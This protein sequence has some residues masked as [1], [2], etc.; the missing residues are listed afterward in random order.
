MGTRIIAAVKALIG[1]AILLYPASALA[2]T[3]LPWSLSQFPDGGPAL[4]EAVA[5]SLGSDAGLAA[6][7]CRA[8]S[9]GTP[10][11]AASVIAGIALAAYAAPP[12][13]SAAIVEQYADC[14]AEI[15]GNIA[16]RNISLGAAVALEA[17]AWGENEIGLGREIEQFVAQCENEPFIRSYDI[18]RG[19]DGLGSQI[20][21]SVTDGP[22]STGSIPIDTSGGGGLPSPN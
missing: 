19:E 9:E 16:D 10:Q 14:C 12:A 3:S 11:Q 15:A 6:Q 7:T 2:Q 5:T 17:R 21:A 22:A 4:T 18:A 13:T 1:F 20:A 8:L